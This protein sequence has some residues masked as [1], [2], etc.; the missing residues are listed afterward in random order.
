[1]Q[2]L[3]SSH[4]SFISFI[5][6][7]FLYLILGAQYAVLTPRW[8]VPDEPAHYN[9]I[10]EIV[11]QGTLPILEV[12]EYQ[13]AYLSELTTKKF[14]SY[15]S[16]D[17]LKYES[18]QPPLYYLLA[19]PIFLIAN[20]ALLPLRLF[21]VAL[22]A[23]VLFFTYLVGRETFPEQP[24]IAV[25]AAGFVA[26]IPQ[27]IAMLA[28]VN[29]DSLSELII[30]AGLWLILRA[31]RLDFGMI[32]L[33]SPQ[34]LGFW[35]LGFLLGAAFLTKSQA[36]VL[37]PVAGAMLLLKWRQAGWGQ[38]RVGGQWALI[39][40]LP[41]LFIGGVGWGRNLAVYGWP[42]FMASIR[43]DQVVAE[44]PRTWQ[45]VEE[46]G[47]AEVLNRFAQT[48]FRSFWGQFG[49]MEVVMDRR[50]YW[51][52]G[53]YSVGLVVGLII[54]IGKFRVCGAR[55]APH[56]LNLPCLL[57]SLSAL[58][59]LGLYLFYNLTYVQ[60]QGRYLFP[61]LAPLGVAAAMSLWAWGGAL[62]ALTRRPISWIVPAG[63]LAAMILLAQVALYRFIIPAWSSAAG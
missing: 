55:S 39:L 48:T 11:E 23:G 8:Q 51:A 50:V 18:W 58:L 36:Y 17:S 53:I 1:M 33:R 34:V 49:W 35:G 13:Q 10:R 14:P 4:I 63:A 22:G 27:H 59:T 43:H 15:L 45:W 16:I 38:W 46:K 52:L 47:A 5:S 26:F 12:G 54:N 29:N 44:Q 37:A 42:D 30:A 56:T 21:S 20:G 61:A 32:R 40:F 41:A 25:T 7:V 9:Y 24:F 57:L 3:F 31:V 60:H 19:A 6:I 28:G 2:P 62:A